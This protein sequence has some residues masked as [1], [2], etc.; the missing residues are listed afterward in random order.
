MQ[1][2][3]WL[4]LFPEYLHPWWVR[5]RYKHLGAFLNHGMLE[6]Q[7]CD[8]ASEDPAGSFLEETTTAATE[9]MTRALRQ[10]FLPW[11]SR[12]SPVYT[13][14][15]SWIPS[16]SRRVARLSLAEDKEQGEA[17]EGG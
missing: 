5:A 16:C 6:N 10:L 1:G 13:V 12:I 3:F 2:L 14:E 4:V 17:R 9:H 7:M 15:Q 11:R 8:S